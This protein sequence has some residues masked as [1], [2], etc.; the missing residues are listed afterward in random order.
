MTTRAILAI[1]VLALTG[2]FANVTQAALLTDFSI[3]AGRNVVIGG[4]TIVGFPS[5]TARVG[6]GTTVVGVGDGTVAGRAGIYGDLRTG[7][8]VVLNNGSFV[9]G[10]I[11]NPDQLTVGSGVSYGAHVIAMSDLPTLPAATLFSGG[12]LDQSVGNNATMNL[13]PGSYDVISL[14]GGATL[15]LT[16]GNYFLTRLSAG[17]GL[18]INANL[19]SGDL[20][21]YVTQDFSAGGVTAMNL[22]GGDWQNV[23][24]ETHSTTVNAFRI[25]GGSGTNW[26]G[27][28]FTPN[29][30]IHLGSGSSTGNI[31]GHLWAG[32]DVDLEHGLFVAPP[33]LPP[34][35]P[36]HGCSLRGLA[37]WDLPGV[38]G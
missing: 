22:A 1:S 27:T 13:L 33:S 35:L 20:K 3:Y 19:G 30:G 10:T 7:D 18:R 38:A 31:E 32:T 4:S 37:Y 24:V 8:D 34:C 21:L 2:L 36:R 11:T 28:V 16:A 12:T 14:G 15:N 17:N 5:R 6:A 23:Y 25:G 26:Q 9:T 29:G